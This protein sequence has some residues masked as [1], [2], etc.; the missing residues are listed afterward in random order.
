[1]FKIFI[2][3]CALFSNVIAQFSLRKGMMDIDINIVSFS[4]LLEIISSSYVLLGLLFYGI[5]FTLYVYLLSKFELS[6]IYP[7]TMSAGFVLLL[8]F[9]VLLLDET[10]TLSKLIGIILVSA[11][12]IVITL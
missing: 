1:M 4:K 11:G 12:I 9:S 3:I 5:S 6:F 7:I 8:I 10:F 2:I